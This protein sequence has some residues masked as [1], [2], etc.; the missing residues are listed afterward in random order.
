MPGWGI[1]LIIGGVVLAVLLVVGVVTAVLAPALG[2]AKG[3]AQRSVCMSNLRM[4]GRSIQVYETEFNAMPPDMDTLIRHVLGQAQPFKC[5]S[6]RSNRKSDYFVHLPTTIKPPPHPQI[7]IACDRKDNH[8]DGWRNVLFYDGHIE[9][10]KEA[11]FES[12]LKLPRN[13]A[14]A[15]AMN[16]AQGG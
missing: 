4:I 1:G 5:P 8:R 12:E 11:Q 13:A 3:L 14:F 10:M 7:M 2:R 15:K 6:C 9:P 16:K